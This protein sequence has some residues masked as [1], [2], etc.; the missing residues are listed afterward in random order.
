MKRNTL[1]VLDDE[2]GSVGVEGALAL[3][4]TTIACGASFMYLAEPDLARAIAEVG[5][6]VS[7]GILA[8]VAVC[9]LRDLT[10]N[11][12]ER[13][14]G[15]G[16]D[17]PLARAKSPRTYSVDAFPAGGVGPFSP[18]PRPSSNKDASPDVTR[19][20]ERKKVGDEHY[21]LPPD[22]ESREV[23]V[24]QILE[25]QAARRRR[26]ELNAAAVD[27]YNRDA[28]LYFTP[29]HDE[30]YQLRDGLYRGGE[31]VMRPLDDGSYPDQNPYEPL[32]PRY[33]HVVSLNRADGTQVIFPGQAFDFLRRGDDETYFATDDQIDHTVAVELFGDVIES[34]GG[35]I[36]VQTTKAFIRGEEPAETGPRVKVI[37][38]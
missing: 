36:V 7:L 23:Y 24:G 5:F 32:D 10:K 2:R 33:T 27:Q 4:L 38:T 26:D 1:E 11:R 37:I 28:G 3:A 13:Q 19:S 6:P 8:V 17:V 20:W 21:Y 9:L 16:Q 22:S 12:T 15:L 31:F 25:D 35:Q 14:P 18:G 29:D 34:G 30:F